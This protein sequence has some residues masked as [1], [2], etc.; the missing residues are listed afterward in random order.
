MSSGRPSVTARWVA[1]HR[2]RLAPTRPSTPDGDVAAEAA[3]D[4]DVRG[5]FAV[6]LGWPTGMPERTRFVDGEV[7]RALGHGVD[8]IVLVG[9][10]Y[11]G[12]A[13]RFGG[14]A[15]RWFEV[16][17]PSTQ[18]DKRRRLA[19]LG[20]A[21]ADVAYAGVD[22][23]TGDLDRALDAAGHDAARPSL[24]V[25]EGLF[26]SL[27]L[28]AVVAVCRALRER[29]ST[30]SV[31]VAT[32][33]VAPGDGSRGPALHAVVDQLLALVGERRRSEF[34]EGDP[35]KLMVVT[36]WRVAR[37]ASPPPG[38]RAAGRH[39]LALAAEPTPGER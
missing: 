24:F 12:R 9:A 17:F 32:F 31:L 34:F 21:R 28:E 3:L 22:L 13:L 1:A 4:R 33:L 25:C 14:G 2:A 26:T 15:T 39:L 10:G 5:V 35:E 16:D 18:A 36:G 27:T 11:D 37:S 19:A 23:L 29:A 6:P 38:R 20:V 30:G 7:A 8:Q